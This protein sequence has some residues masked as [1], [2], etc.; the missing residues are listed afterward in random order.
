MKKVATNNKKPNSQKPDYKDN[1]YLAKR[2][3]KEYVFP[4]KFKFFLSVF[5][6]FIIAGTT[7]TIAYLIQP[8]LDEVLVQGQQKNVIINTNCHHYNSNHKRC[9]YLFSGSFNELCYRI[10]YRRFKKGTL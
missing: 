3:F 2:L 7:G 5:F 1:L 10:H 6:M 8:A 4:Y 9:L